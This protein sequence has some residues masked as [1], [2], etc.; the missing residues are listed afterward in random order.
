MCG[1]KKHPL[2]RDLLTLLLYKLLNVLNVM[3][4]KLV[5]VRFSIFPSKKTLKQIADIKLDDI[6]IKVAFYF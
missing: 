3:L 2:K 4:R 5:I 1:I 6:L